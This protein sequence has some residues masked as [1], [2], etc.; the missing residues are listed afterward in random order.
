MD[1]YIQIKF[2][3]GLVPEVGVNGA[4]VEDVIDVLMQRL[5]T[6]QRELPCRENAIALTH[7]ETARLFLNERT[8]KRKA[9]GVEGQQRPHV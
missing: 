3:E 4:H 5:H 1:N 9:Q 6:Y 8:R 7:L 2:Q